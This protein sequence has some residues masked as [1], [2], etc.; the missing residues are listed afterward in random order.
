MSGVCAGCGAVS[1]SFYL[2]R[3]YGA[4]PK[5][6]VRNLGCEYDIRDI[7]KDLYLAVL[8]ASKQAQSASFISR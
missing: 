8:Q 7:D 3:I 1:H 6:H 5:N 4:I 2:Y